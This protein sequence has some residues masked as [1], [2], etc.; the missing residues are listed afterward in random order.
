MCVQGFVAG[1]KIVGG[2][3]ALTI[4][5]RF[6]VTNI[7]EGGKDLRTPLHREKEYLLDLDDSNP[8]Y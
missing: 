4:A 2:V 7:Y 5:E 8:Y 1:A 3:I 6:L